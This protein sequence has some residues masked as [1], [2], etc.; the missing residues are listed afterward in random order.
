[1]AREISV[2]LSLKNGTGEHR[3]FFPIRLADKCTG[4]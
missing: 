1:M 3:A 4:V 2:V